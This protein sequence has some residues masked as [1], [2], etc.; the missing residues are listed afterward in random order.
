MIKPVTDFEMKGH[1]KWIMPVWVGMKLMLISQSVLL[2]KYKDETWKTCS[3]SKFTLWYLAL[4]WTLPS[5][6]WV[7]IKVYAKQI[8]LMK[9]VKKTENPF[10]RLLKNYIRKHHLEKRIVTLN[11]YVQMSHDSN[12]AEVGFASDLILP[13]TLQWRQNGRQNGVTNH[14]PHDCLLNH[15]FKSRS[16]KTSKLRVTGLCA[17]NSP[18]NGEFTALMANNAENGFIDDVIMRHKTN[19]I[20][21]KWTPVWTPFEQDLTDFSYRYKRIVRISVKY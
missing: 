19:Q 9:L 13:W 3:Y 8:L 20:P 5:D 1:W 2:I 12:A 7:H 14:Q 6:A 18:V 15:L 10:Y 17:G 21:V 16:K 4:L 11:Y